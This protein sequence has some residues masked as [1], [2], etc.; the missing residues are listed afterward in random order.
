MPDGVRLAEEV[1][2]EEVGRILR[3]NDEDVA[4]LLTKQTGLLTAPRHFARWSVLG[5]AVHGSL[6]FIKPM[7]NLA[8]VSLIATGKR[9]E[10]GI[11]YEILQ[12]ARDEWTPSP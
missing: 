2:I 9:P 11:G 5:Q 7:V 12:S 4:V 6:G 10:K 1:R 3:R 8:Q